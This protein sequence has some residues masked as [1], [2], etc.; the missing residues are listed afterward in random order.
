MIAF[1]VFT[2]IARWPDWPG[3]CV[4]TL[5]VLTSSDMMLICFPPI[6]SISGVAPCRSLMWT[7]TPH[8]EAGTVLWCSDPPCRPRGE[9]CD[10]LDLAV[11]SLLPVE[12][13]ALLHLNYYKNNILKILWGRDIRFNYRLSSRNVFIYAKDQIQIY[14]Q[15]VFYIFCCIIFFFGG[16]GGGG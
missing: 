10:R 7:G 6:A 8:C 12:Q 13:N 4:S 16:G 9:L 14:Y 11:K 3:C 1:C 5:P 15:N 2:C